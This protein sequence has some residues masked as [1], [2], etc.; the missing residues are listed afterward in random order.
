ML[1]VEIVV[2]DSEIHTK[3]I[4]TLGKKNLEFLDIKTGGL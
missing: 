1:Y 4:S 2:L 3:Y